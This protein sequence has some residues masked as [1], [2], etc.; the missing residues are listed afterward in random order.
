MSMADTLTQL[1]YNDDIEYIFTNAFDMNDLKCIEIEPGMIEELHAGN[2]EI[3]GDLDNET[4]LVSSSNSYKVRQADSS[5]TVLLTSL[6]NPHDE[7]SKSV[8][9]STKEDIYTAVSC[10]YILE[11]VPPKLN[12]LHDILYQR[13]YKGILTPEASPE[14]D[15][16]D[17]QKMMDTNTRID[18][19]FDKLKSLVQC[20]D[21]ELME[22]LQEIN[23]IE[24]GN[25][26]RI[27]DEAYLGQCVQDMLLCVME[28][29]IDYK[30]F[31]MLQIVQNMTE[32]PK[33]VIEHCIKIYCIPRKEDSGETCWGFDE[34]KVCV[35]CAKQILKQ[36]GNQMKAPRFKQEWMD[37]LPYGLT[38][39]EEMLRGHLMVMYDTTSRENVWHIFEEKQLNLDPKIRFKELFERKDEWDMDGITPYLQSLIKTGHSVDKLLL[40]HSRMVRRKDS[41]GNQKRT[42]ISRNAKRNR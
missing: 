34:S 33:E 30:R 6:R 28:H 32:F 37:S 8:D 23:A 24:I 26:W 10:V 1:K 40:R 5:N 7:E 2:L 13:P 19:S 14:N 9:F 15:A 35:F 22:A 18:L 16:D 36:H 31:E 17:D 21:K 3:R 11:K 42:Y 4:V 29:S 38:P 41:N 25:E 39:K 12:T 20:S 27:I